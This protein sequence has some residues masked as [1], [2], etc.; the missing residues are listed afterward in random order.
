MLSINLTPV[1]GVDTLDLLALPE[2]KDYAFSIWFTSSL[3][4]QRL[5]ILTG[6]YLTLR[7]DDEV[8]KR[9][10]SRRQRGSIACLNIRL[11][12]DDCQFGST[13]CAISVSVRPCGLFL[14]I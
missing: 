14:M 9:T 8:V 2:Y 5:E 6:K 4:N 12:F 3:N 11:Q 7:P 10:S 13:F 1:K